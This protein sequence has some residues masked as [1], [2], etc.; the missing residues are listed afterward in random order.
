[1]EYLFGCYTR[2][3]NPRDRQIKPFNWGEESLLSCAHREGIYVAATLMMEPAYSLSEFADNKT[4]S[5]IP[6]LGMK[7][8]EAF[9][10]ILFYVQRSSWSEHGNRRSSIK[11]LI[12]LRSAILTSRFARTVL[13]RLAAAISGFLSA[14]GRRQSPFA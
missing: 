2:Q 4:M 12:N 9:F 14:L 6:L 3:S 10:R 1:M 11:M 5:F 8:H 7:H 13:A